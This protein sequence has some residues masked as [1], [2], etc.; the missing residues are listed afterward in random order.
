MDLFPTEAEIA[1]WRLA[2]ADEELFG[3]NDDD[4]ELRLPKA[5]KEAAAR[6]AAA[7]GRS[8]AALH[9]LA[10]ALYVFGPEHVG[11]IVARRYGVA[12]QV[13]PDEAPPVA[14]A[15]AGSEQV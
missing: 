14:R 13:A 12:R 2:V 4:Y 15:T 9:R 6:R 5:L 10:V 8:P 1:Q 7:E 11:M 3:K